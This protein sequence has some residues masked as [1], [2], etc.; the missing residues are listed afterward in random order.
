M[1]RLWFLF[2][3]S[4]CL[5]V[6]A[7][8]ADE[9]AMRCPAQIVGVYAGKADTKGGRP[10]P[11]EWSAVSLP[12]NWNKRNPDH[13]DS[14]WYRIDWRQDCADP[15]AA[16][17]ALLFESVVL[18]GEI[19]VNDH[20][21]WSDTQLSEPLSRSWNMPRYWLLPDVWVTPGINTIWVRVVSAPGQAMGLG[22]VHIGD[23]RNIYSQYEELRWNRRTLYVANLIVSGVIGV[24][25]FC[26]WIASR[27][28]TAYGWYAFSSLCWVVF[29]WNILAT[30]PW[31]LPSSLALARVNTIAFLLCVTSFCIFTWRIADKRLPR[32]ERAVW[33][34]T[35]GLIALIIMVPDAYVG[36]MQLSGMIFGAPLFL[37]NCISFTI[38]SLISRKIECLTTSFFLSTLFVACIHDL[39]LLFHTAYSSYSLLPYT[40][41]IITLCLSAILGLRHAHNVRRIERFNLE[42]AEGVAN[43]RSE[44]ATALENKFAAERA[45]IRLQ[46]RLQLANDLHDGLGGALVHMMASVEQEDGPLPRQHILSMLKLIRDDLR[47]TIDSNSSVGIKVPATPKEWIAP[48]RHRFTTLFDEM[49]IEADWQYP[50][51]WHHPPSALSST[52]SSTLPSTL[53]CLT[54]TRV[55]EEALTNIIKHSRAR[56]VKFC[57]LQ[58]RKGDLTLRIEDDGV[59]FDVEAV[60]RSGISVGMRSMSTRMARLGGSLG[61]SSQPGRTLLVAR[62]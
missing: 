14:I 11:S 55:M 13:H 33:T 31:P 10:A 40:N 54:L 24:L 49:G 51:H 19:F 20:F 48:L 4:L 58:S 9:S 30:S 52:L 57:L 22:K 27:R 16:P 45:N 61:V 34:T 21:L 8:K 53:Q 46:D 7:A 41:I 29:I 26:I 50:D 5:P 32:T 6:W 39:F 62:L 28:Q 12:D 38:Y 23:P 25:F 42:L 44:L 18:A 3:F 56:H 15:G 59:G 60:K 36:H 2:L 37:L 47:Q 1:K 35:I 43:A 17:V